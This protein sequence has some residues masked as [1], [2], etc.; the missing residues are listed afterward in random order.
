MATVA[1]NLGARGFVQSDLVPALLASNAHV[2]VRAGD[3]T[4][5]STVAEYL[6][7]ELDG[8]LVLDVV[9]DVGAT[10]HSAYERLSIKGGGEYAVTAAAVSVELDALGHVLT[11][12]V[13]F[14]SVERRSRRCAAAES[15][16]IGRPLDEEVIARAGRA[17]ADELDAVD[18]P[19]AS[20][21]YRRRLVPVALA[22]AITKITAEVADAT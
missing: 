16:L 11:A 9:F 15:E 21:S 7:R 12:R 4:T 5:T 13:A 17:A 10:T 20:A 1:G 19:S 8:H 6:D 2:R 14:G 18:D 3:H 22:R